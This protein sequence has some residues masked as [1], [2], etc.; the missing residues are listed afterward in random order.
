MQRLI[1]PLI[2]EQIIQRFNA[3]K[4]FEKAFFQRVAL[5]QRN[6]LSGNPCVSLSFETFKKV[7]AIPISDDMARTL[8]IKTLESL[9]FSRGYYYTTDK[10]LNIEYTF[11]S[12]YKIMSDG[13]ALVYL[14]PFFSEVILGHKQDI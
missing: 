14:D 2:Q 13:S 4:P 11:L 1:C 6:D 7:N 5:I 3:L 9:L 12:G 8:L 10:R